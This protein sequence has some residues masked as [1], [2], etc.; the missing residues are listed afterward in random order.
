MRTH[1][2]VSPGSAAFGELL[3]GLR[4]A[5]ELHAAGDR[6]MFLAPRTHRLVLENTPFGHG[7][8]DPI[9]GTLDRAVPD[10]IRQ[11]GCDSVV[12]LDLMSTIFMLEKHR[13]DPAFLDHLPVATHALDIWDLSRSDLVFDMCESKMTLRES[14][15]TLVPARLVPVPFARSD[16]RGA[17]C[18]LPPLSDRD[19]KGEIRAQLGLAA[20]DRLVMFTT[21]Q[22]QAHG[23]T[24]W[25]TRAVGTIPKQIVTTCLDRDPRVHVA[26]VGPRAVVGELARYHHLPS[27]APPHFEQLMRA[28]DLL[29]TA[30]Q[31]SSG[32][33]VALAAGIPAIA[34][35]GESTE[36]KF[37]IF[38]LGM[39][40]FLE[41]ALRNN[42]YTTAVPA[43]DVAALGD[44]LHAEIFDDAHR[45]RRL[46]E[47]RAYVADVRR[48]PSGRDVLE[49]Y[50]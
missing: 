8:I 43:V 46:V 39:Y 21:A 47:M 45:A 29:L 38:P 13:T 22:F 1:L 10:I 40:S 35:I 42:A 41:P 24:P 25:Q 18:C 15:R 44:V 36:Y 17:F 48:L 3:L 7:T 4:L 26:H 12:F 28:S 34:A 32:I 30:N 20:D 11:R 23:A 9:L 2:F 5:Y 19:E 16:A 27:M 14:A 49:S 37:R 33:S 31:P 50:R 6:V